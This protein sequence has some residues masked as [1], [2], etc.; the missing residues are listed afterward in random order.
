MYALGFLAMISSYYTISIVDIDEKFLIYISKIVSIASILT[1]I[2]NGML[3]FS[4]EH[5]VAFSGRINPFMY[6]PYIFISIKHYNKNKSMRL[7]MIFILIL[8]LIDIVWTDSR[9]SILATICIIVGYFIFTKLRIGK[10]KEKIKKILKI[11]CLCVLILRLF[12]PIIYIFLYENYA[13]ELNQIS[14]K[15][16]K[17]YFFSGRQGVWNQI[18]KSVEGKELIGTGDINYEKQNL[19][20]HNEFIN[21]YYCWG[22]P[23]AII[24]DVLIYI[25]VRKCINNIR[26]NRDLLILLCF[27]ANIVC[28]I[29]ETYLYTIHFFIFNVIPLSYILNRNGESNENNRNAII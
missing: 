16:T 15:Y 27:L 3:N 29:F 14:Y 19:A 9:A 23:V 18:Y 26:D 8:N 21:L 28:T 22:F 11:V 7:I 13:D 10:N 24:S 6:L 4:L 17:K 5:G 20:A 1:I 12:L 25:I 2:F